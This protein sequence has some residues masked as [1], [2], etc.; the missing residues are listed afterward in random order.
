MSDEQQIEM[1][2][3]EYCQEYV[4][5]D[6]TTNECTTG[7]N[8]SLCPYDV[9]DDSSRGKPLD[10]NDSEVNRDEQYD[11]SGLVEDTEDGC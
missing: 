7:C 2:H 8:N 3:C 11:Y 10:F 9:Y 4:P 5:V 6:I 1:V